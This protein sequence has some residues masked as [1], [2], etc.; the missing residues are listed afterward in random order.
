M[1]KQAT[2]VM[3]DDRLDFTATAAIKVGDVVPMGVIGVGIALTD[4]TIGASGTL[5]TEGVFNIVSKT[6][7]AFALWDVLYWDDT[8]K[9]LTK[10]TTSNA[11]AGMAVAAKASA[12]AIVAIRLNY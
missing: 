3:G 12:D 11:R 1:A 7:E 2:Y 5:K 8:A 9:A 4:I 6:G 10:T